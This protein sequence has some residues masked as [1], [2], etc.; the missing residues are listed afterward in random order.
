M[1]KVRVEPIAFPVVVGT[2]ELLAGAWGERWP[3]RVK[4]RIEHPIT[5]ELRAEYDAFVARFNAARDA[6][7]A[8][9]AE[10]EE[11]GWAHGGMVEED[12]A[13]YELRPLVE[14]VYAETHEEHRDRVRA[15]IKH[16]AETGQWLEAPEPT[17]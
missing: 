4:E 9:V 17:L 1:N 14:F 10:G 11:L 5:P 7:D 2:D 16:H 13:V 15:I 8:V 3:R 6:F 12:P